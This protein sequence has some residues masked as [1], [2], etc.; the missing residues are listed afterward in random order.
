MLSLLSSSMSVHAGPEL[1]RCPAQGARRRVS[2]RRWGPSGRC[3]GD[4]GGGGGGAAAGAG[5]TRLVAAV[6]LRER[7]GVA[8]LVAAGRFAPDLLRGGTQDVRASPLPPSRCAARPL[9]A[10][11]LAIAGPSSPR[12][13]ASACPAAWTGPG[14]WSRAPS[15]PAGAAARRVSRRALQ[16]CTPCTRGRGPPPGCPGPCPWPGARRRRSCSSHGTP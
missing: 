3:G 14:C 1:G 11:A 16:R 7:T 2:T 10:R 15:S 13:G 8:G 4:G 6:E 9:G 12:A 5:L